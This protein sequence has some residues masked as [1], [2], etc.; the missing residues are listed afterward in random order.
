MKDSS[1]FT[2]LQVDFGTMAIDGS[3]GTV[4]VYDTNGPLINGMGRIRI[5]DQKK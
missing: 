5:Q 3:T 4:P 2:D 1:I